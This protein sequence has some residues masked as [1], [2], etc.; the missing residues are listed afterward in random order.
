MRVAFFFF[1]KKNPVKYTTYT[2]PITTPTHQHRCLYNYY[3]TTGA[4]DIQTKINNTT[5][6]A[7]YNYNKAPTPR[8]LFYF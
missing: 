1:C 4:L 7:S 6:A 5:A 3:N 8:V 2:G